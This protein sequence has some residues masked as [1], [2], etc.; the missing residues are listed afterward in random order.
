MYNE[1]D[2]VSLSGMPTAACI[3]FQRLKEDVARTA[4]QACPENP[5]DIRTWKGR[6]ITCFQED[7]IRR[8]NGRISEKWFYTHIKADRERIP[9]VDILNLLSRYVG[10]EGWEDYQRQHLTHTQETLP[11]TNRR[12]WLWLAGMLVLLLSLVLL[13]RQSLRSV[14]YRFYFVN[15][16]SKQAVSPGDIDVMLLSDGE[17]PYRV[18]IDSDGC[19]VVDTRR[20]RVQLVIRSSYYKND[21]IVRVLD[22]ADRTERVALETDDYA[23]M[24]RLFSGAD[25]DHWQRRRRQLDRM[26]ADDARIYQLFDDQ[27]VGI[28]LY[29]KQEFINKLTMPLRS[30]RH[31]DVL[32]IRYRGDQI[33][34]LRFRQKNDEKTP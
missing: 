5:A 23:W 1:H 22:K 33:Q 4:R 10:Y 7:L 21:T 28:E 34:V 8:V 32:D 9:R 30:L 2:F 19:L 3:C 31:V 13:Y 16:Y 25:V 27:A 29:N 18:P 26:I 20:D 11:A 14:T 24:I 15:A 6:E 12:K 17:S